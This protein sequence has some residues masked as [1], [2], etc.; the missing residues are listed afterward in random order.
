[1]HKRQLIKILFKS[2]TPIIQGLLRP[3]W[4]RQ[5]APYKHQ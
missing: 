5:R 1:V 2:H 4:G 3:W